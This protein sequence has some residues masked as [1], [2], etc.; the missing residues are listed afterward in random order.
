MPTEAQR[1]AISDITSL[2]RAA[3]E[4][5]ARVQA[6]ET[7]R[8]LARAIVVVAG[9]LAILLLL[10]AVML[11]IVYGPSY[12]ETATKVCLVFILTCALGDGARH[13]A[14]AVIAKDTELTAEGYDAMTKMARQSVVIQGV[15][16][17]WMQESLRLSHR[18]LVILKKVEESI[19]EQTTA[20]EGTR[21]LSVA[22]DS[23]AR[24]INGTD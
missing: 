19:A 22:R 17:D 8:Q 12:A 2:R 9:V 15:V 11:E 1:R 23:V 18:D 13:V 4:A 20:L 24:F 10:V 5:I 21:Q 7:C 3:K 14:D 6:A 16:R